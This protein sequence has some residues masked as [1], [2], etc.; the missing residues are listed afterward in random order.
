[1]SAAAICRKD[2]VA[3]VRLAGL[4]LL[5]VGVGG[6]FGAMARYQ[7]VAQYFGA[8]AGATI[9]SAAYLVLIPDPATQLFTPAWPAPPAWP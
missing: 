7:L 4:Q 1:M 2:A 6:F 9:G 5:V 3:D 8:L